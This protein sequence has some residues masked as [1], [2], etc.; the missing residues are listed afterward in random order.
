M[1]KIYL[2]F[3]T[4]LSIIAGSITLM[5]ATPNTLRVHYFRYDDNYTNFN[6]WMWA[7]KPSSLDGIQHNFDANNKDEYGIFF[8]VDLNTFYPSSTEVG[9]IIKQ[10]AWGG[11]QEP[12]G[13]RY[14]NLENIET[15][16]G[17][18][19][20]YFVQGE[21][22]FGLS[23]ADLAN[24]IPDYSPKILSA[25]FDTQNKIQATFSHIPQGNIVVYE[26]DSIVHTTTATSRNVIISLDS[27]DISKKYS[28]TV[29]FDETDVKTRNISISNL[30]DT[31]QFESLYTYGGELGVI[32]D[33]SKTTFRLWA[34]LSD[35]V[36][37][38]IYNQGHPNYD[39][40]G[41]LNDELTP[42]S[43][44][45]L[46][47]IE[48]GA[49]EVVL[50]ENLSGKYYTFTVQNGVEVHEV[51]DPYAYSTGANGLRGMIV[52]F[53][54]TD[55]NGWD[56]N[57]RPKDIVNPVDYTVYELHIRDLTT[58]SSWNGSALNRGKFTGFTESGTSYTDKNGLTVTT[59][60]DHLDELGANAIQLLPIFDFGYIDEVQLALNPLYPNTFNWGYMPYN[61][62]TLEGSY[63]TNPFDGSVRINEFKQ[64]M[65]ALNS[66]DMH[67]IMDVVY[68]HT[69]ESETSNFHKIVPG[70]YHRLNESGGFSN[71]SGTGN[72]T[73]SDRSMMRKFMVESTVFWATEY[74]LSGFRFDLMEL[75]DVETMN[76]IIEALHEI[77]ETIVVYGEPWIGGTSSPL[78]A[79]ERAGKGNMSKIPN[80]GSFN[81]ITRDA[82]KGSV[83]TQP[84]GA[85]LQGDF[86]NQKVE[87]IKYGIL[88]GQDLSF[89]SLT[90]YH[91]NPNQT[92]NYISAHDNNTLYDKL[93][94]SGVSLK[95]APT[96]QKMGN[97]MVL[98]SEGLPFLH[99]GVDFLRSKPLEDGT[100]YD[101]N[102]YESS[103]KVNQL[104]WTRKARYIDVFNYYKGL[105][106]IR[107]DY[108]HFRI[109]NFS[110][111]NSR[112]EFIDTGKNGVIAYKIL[113][114][115]SEPEIV[116]IHN[117]TISSA[118]VSLSTGK[119]FEYFSDS[120]QINP[121]GTGITVT[122]QA[123]APKG[124]TIILVEQLDRKLTVNED[125]V[126][127]E[128][129]S[130]Y[131][132][133]DN[134][135]VDDPSKVSHT[136]VNT[137]T[138]GLFNITVAYENSF[139]RIDYQ[140]FTLVVYGRH[141][142][143]NVGGA[144]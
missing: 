118:P 36:K 143:I 12:G 115:E 132:P 100:G 16:D 129:G 60:L 97:A 53:D 39:K 120:T 92:V 34:P 1:K 76:Q 63:S 49:Y 109:D 142:N 62:N 72:E 35:S 38:N 71:G 18:A 24:R 26:N 68:N 123:F 78:P 107:K 96:L 87:G 4:L 138:P 106:Q 117:N 54:S 122:D 127:V 124:S 86:S 91:T 41:E 48:S 126:Y 128:Q 102:S 30:Y 14:I 121:R 75:H 43:T 130:T 66:R 73:A 52:D 64:L 81:D 77:D 42:V 119:V 93:R 21:T 7:F 136:T 83:F 15:K 89:N 113:G 23:D 88:G 11:Y 55:P 19:H 108:N 116:V 50:D 47:R 135:S 44:H 144:Q 5:A 32:L 37:V 134:I 80:I 105:I 69:G 56:T 28:I 99:A 27:V 10:G 140:H 133:L 139:G 22:V 110:D 25:Y 3:L 90:G 141:F 103:D 85:W 104:D 40:D 29:N 2:L 125:V 70:Y 59:G 58:H 95:D 46:T 13:N 61:F 84:E 98:L 20:A 112:L 131:N 79:A 67:V 74:N 82:I 101:H 65:M 45:E 111:I 31:A 33:E 94:L 57:S 8:D 17:I 9:I 6:F 114:L 51:V 137:S